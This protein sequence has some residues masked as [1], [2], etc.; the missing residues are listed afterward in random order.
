MKQVSRAISDR[1]AAAASA[2]QHA[3]KAFDQAIASGITAAFSLK[4]PIILIDVLI[5]DI[6][7]KEELNLCREPA[8]AGDAQNLLQF[9]LQ[10]FSLA[11]QFNRANF[12]KANLPTDL[13][14]LIE[15]SINNSNDPFGL[16]RAVAEMRYGNS[17]CFDIEP[18]DYLNPGMG[19]QGY[20]FAHILCESIQTT[21]NCQELPS[22]LLRLA[23]DG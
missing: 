14:R 1:S 22:I 4:K 6:H 9:L 20:P 7:L 8:G 13:D 18:V 2:I 17:S 10:P 5:E 21:Y 12:D 23:R 11:V 16:L 19:I 3:F 15:T